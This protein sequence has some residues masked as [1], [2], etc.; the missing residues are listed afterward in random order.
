MQAG[1]RGRADGR[2]GGRGTCPL[3]STPLWEPGGNCWGAPSGVT[4]AQARTAAGSVVH[5]DVPLSARARVPLST[6]ATVVGSLP[7][8]TYLI[9]IFI[10][11]DGNETGLSSLG[12][13]TQDRPLAK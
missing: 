3:A 4:E 10:W 6:H 11:S 9:L 12:K 8:R 1:A 5:K 2:T 13:D 7:F